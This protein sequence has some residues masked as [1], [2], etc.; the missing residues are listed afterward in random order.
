MGRAQG[1]TRIFIT[2]AAQRRGT[3]MP[4]PKRRRAEHNAGAFA[5]PSGAGGGGGDQ[6]VEVAYFYRT[7]WGHHDEFMELFTRNHLPVLQELVRTGLML[8]V[9]VRVP[10][11]H[12]EGRADW[13]VM[14]AIV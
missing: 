10:R 13:D 6:P 1:W 8:E 11:F 12:G 14:V 5:N 4:E 9:R 3:E 2:S 7:K